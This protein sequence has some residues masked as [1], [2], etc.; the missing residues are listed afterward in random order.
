MECCGARAL[1]GG[2]A[3][4][5]AA[6]LNGH[7]LALLERMP[8][9]H[10]QVAAAMRIVALD[11]CGASAGLLRSSIETASVSTHAYIAKVS[12]TH[13][14]VQAVYTAHLPGSA[15]LALVATKGQTVL[16]RVVEP[17]IDAAGAGLVRA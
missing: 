10:D 11:S 13:L 3:G 9:V 7:H 2:G 4:R 17:T 5:R 6:G 16:L 1:G 15:Q 12:C 8:Q 14:P